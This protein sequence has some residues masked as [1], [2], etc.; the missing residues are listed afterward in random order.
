MTED[1]VLKANSVNLVNMTEAHGKPSVWTDQ[2]GAEAVQLISLTSVPYT[3]NGKNQ[4]HFYINSANASAPAPSAAP[5][6]TPSAATLGRA[7][8]LSNAVD[9]Q[10]KGL[11]RFRGTAP[12]LSIKS[13]HI[14]TNMI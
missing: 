10:I 11:C 7:V 1:P 13:I 12:R 5:T 4:V 9:W 8:C 14:Q 6:A 3:E 2:I